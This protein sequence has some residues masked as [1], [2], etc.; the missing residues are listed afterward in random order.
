M[1]TQIEDFKKKIRELEATVTIGKG[2]KVKLE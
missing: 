2:E 1:L